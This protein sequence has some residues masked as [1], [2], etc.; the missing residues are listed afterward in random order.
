[1]QIGG[2]GR[3]RVA[4]KVLSAIRFGFRGHIEPGKK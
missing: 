1:M 2:V 3:V 4:E